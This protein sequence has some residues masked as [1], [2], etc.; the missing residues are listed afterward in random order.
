MAAV[1]SA[2]TRKVPEPWAT[3][4]GLL[5]LV[6]LT[7]ATGGQVVAHASSAPRSGTRAVNTT[8]TTPLERILEVAAVKD[9]RALPSA[10]AFTPLLPAHLAL[11]SGDLYN[12]VTWASPA[13]GFGVFITSP[14]GTAGSRA[15]H[16]DQ[17]LDSAADL[18]S[19]SF[20]MNAF[21]SVLQPVSL[22]NGT[23][24]EM[25]QEHAPWLGEW[26]LM[27]RFGNIAVE[28]DGLISK[29]GLEQ[30]AASLVP[31]S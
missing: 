22:A 31:F 30:F 2:V 3:R 5:A 24:F 27:R 12:R 18:A 9:L 20:P 28:I 13:G 7:F 6:V 10:M 16:M 17:S 1:E 29:Q 25:Q 11:P 4:F 8:Q 14:Y 19:P 23:W 21:K 26:I 15:I